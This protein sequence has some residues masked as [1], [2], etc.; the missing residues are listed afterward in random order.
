MLCLFVYVHTYTFI[1]F[2]KHIIKVWHFK[3]MWSFFSFGNVFLKTVKSTQNLIYT[4]NW[5]F[6][7]RFCSEKTKKETRVKWMHQKRGLLRGHYVDIQTE[8]LGDPKFKHNITNIQGRW[9]RDNFITMEKLVSVYT[10]ETLR[11]TDGC[12]WPACNNRFLAWDLFTNYVAAFWHK[13]FSV[14]PQTF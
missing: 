13:L 8:P 3:S 6:W 12:S 1:K 11:K 9:Y 14:Y 7:S 4:N 5:Q 2:L 10:T